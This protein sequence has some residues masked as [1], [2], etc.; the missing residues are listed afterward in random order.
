MPGPHL[1]IET[2][3]RDGT[4]GLFEDA[5]RSK[6]AAEAAQAAQTAKAQED[7]QEQVAP[8]VPV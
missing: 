2:T 6:E 3:G 4:V 5:K 1:L 7:D 8:D